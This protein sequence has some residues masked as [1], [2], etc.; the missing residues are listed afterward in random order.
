MLTI[1]LHGIDDPTC[2]GASH[3]HGVAVMMDGSV[4]FCAELERHTRQKH[5][6]NLGL[7]AETLL[8]G[9][10][11]NG[12]PAR[13]ALVNSFAGTDFRSVNGMVEITGAAALEVPDMVADCPGHV[14]VHHRPERHNVQFFT[15]CH[16]M[17]HLATCLPFF[18]PFAAGS[19]LVHIDGGASRSCASAWH[20]DGR[21]LKCLD[22][23]WHPGLKAAVNNFNASQLS[24]WIL[25]LDVSDHLSMPGKLMGL[26]SL[27]R[28]DEA[29]MSWLARHEWMRTASGDAAMARRLLQRCLP[30]LD[31]KEFSP[32]DRGCQVLAACMQRQL[33]TE[34]LEYIRAYKRATGAKHLYFSGGAALNIHSNARI[35]GELGFDTVSIPPA[36]SDTGLALGA[37]AFL[38]WRSGSVLRKHTAFLNHIGPGHSTQGNEPGLPVVTTSGQAARAIAD[39]K[40]VGVWVGDAELG[41]RALGHRS[42][43]ARPDWVELR[44]RLSESVKQRE[45]YRPVAPVLLEEVAIDALR[46]YK[47]GSVLGRYMLGAWTLEPGWVEAFQGCV[48]A[49]GTVRAQVVDGKADQLGH[50]RKLLSELR[51]RYDIQGVIN[52]SFNRRGE[53]IVLALQEATRSATAMGLDAI[54]LPKL[55]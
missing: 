38:E 26:A 34:V 51:S 36:P 10:L 54:W 20:W 16:E 13:I 43:L 29:A 35:E 47:P 3:D 37:A 21:T 4:L 52:T 24:R 39:G 30:Q 11:H 44:K 1:G 45:W 7:H 8:G 14:R 5:D 42:I 46:G 2:S 25:G 53:P 40:L 15:V 41:P 48:H 27:G 50:I 19:L 9:L 6:G 18:G 33:G 17:A 49:D 12:Q 23:G 28:S 22:H 31:L 55:G 32:R